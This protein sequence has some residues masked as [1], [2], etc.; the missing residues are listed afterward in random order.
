M[1]L[2]GHIGITLGLSLGID[3]S[4]HKLRNLLS[5]SRDAKHPASVAKLDTMTGAL[6]YRF[7]IVGSLLPDIIDKP[8]GIYLLRDTFSNGRI[9]A[10]SLLFVLILLILG[11]YRYRK[12]GKAGVLILSLGSGFHLVLDGMWHTP[13]TLLWPVSGFIFPKHDVSNWLPDI[14]KAVETKPVAYGPEIA[15]LVIIVPLVLEILRQGKLLAF[16]KKGSI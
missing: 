5:R 1:L 14:I 15:G 16:I 4:H 12:Y 13:D 9:F 7:V 8:I 3:K 10:H 11:V 2:F 6:D